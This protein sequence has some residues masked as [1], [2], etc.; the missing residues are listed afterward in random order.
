MS[1]AL[2]GELSELGRTRLDVHLEGCPECRAFEAETT[3]VSRLLRSAAPEQMAVPILLP[4]TRRLSTARMLQAGAAAA[5]VALVAALSVL[6]SVGQP[7]TASVP[8]I[9]LSPTAS[10]GHDD[11]LAPIRNAPPRPDFRT[12]L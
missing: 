3:A 6:H 8:Q 9:K 12:A 7:Q 10:L 1:L 11:E 2:D 4:R 5:A